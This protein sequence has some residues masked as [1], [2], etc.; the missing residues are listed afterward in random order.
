VHI[1]IY[2]YIYISRSQ[3]RPLLIGALCDLRL[4]ARGNFITTGIMFTLL[5]LIPEHVKSNI[6]TYNH[7]FLC[8]IMPTHAACLLKPTS[9]FDRLFVNLLCLS[10]INISEASFLK[11]FL[12]IVYGRQTSSDI[13]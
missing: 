10:L 2:I 6:A 7:R 11:C 1:Y 5:I 4:I 3:Q 13:Q 12:G 9:D 8:F